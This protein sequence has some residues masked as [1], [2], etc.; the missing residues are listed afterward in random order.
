MRRRR[1]PTGRPPRPG[2]SEH[3]DPR[4]RVLGADLAAASMPD[5]SGSRT[6]MTTSSGWNFRACSTASAAVPAR[7]RPG[8][9]APVEERDQPCRTTSWSSTTSNRITGRASSV[10]GQVL[11]SRGDANDDT[12]AAAGRCPPRA[13]RP[14]ASRGRACSPGPDAPA[15]A[16]AGSNPRPLSSTVRRSLV[17]SSSTSATRL[18]RPGMAGGIAQRLARDLQRLR[19]TAVAERGRSF[20]ALVEI[21]LDL[22]QGVQPQLIT[23]AADAGRTVR[24]GA[25]GDRGRSCGCRGSKPGRR[26]SPGRP[27]PGLGRVLRHQR[28]DVLERQRHCV[29]AL[30]DPVVE[31]LPDAVALFHD[32]QLPDLLVQPRVLDRDAGVV[33]K[34]LDQL[35]V[36]GRELTGPALVGQVQVADGRP[37]TVTGTRA[38]RSSADGSAEAV[39]IGMRCD[40]RDPVR[41]ALADD[42]PEQPVPRR[43]RTDEDPLLGCDADRDEALDP[44]EVIDDPEGGVAGIGE[45]HTR[46]TMSWS[47][48]SRS[49]TPAIARVAASSASRASAGKVESLFAVDLGTPRSKPTSG[50][51]ELMGDRGPALPGQRSRR[52]A[53]TA[54]IAA[55]VPASRP[56][57]R[58]P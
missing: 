27:R 45:V 2:T 43:W 28:L 13:G 8:S 37:L 51:R 10:T 23:R 15:R 52:A 5:P 9:L 55:C 40:V 4:V 56:H 39:Q 30:D 32:R 7:P 1:S 20:D 35:L 24:G 50:L 49:S 41:A 47:T 48:T 42:Q 26:R 12:C 21:D 46:S 58:H 18:R 57:P 29:E 11:R 53:A 22:D 36:R 54:T 3:H 25:A 14:C 38:A 34:Q 31:L 33:G 6:S 16:V 19:A 44:A 17:P